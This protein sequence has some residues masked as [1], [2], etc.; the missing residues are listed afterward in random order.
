[1]SGRKTVKAPPLAPDLADARIL[2]TSKGIARRLGCSPDF[3]L[4]T[5]MAAPGC[6]IRRLGGR[7]YCFEDELIAWLRNPSPQEPSQTR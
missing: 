1:M 2:W 7:I 3:V 5:L 6:P 4:N